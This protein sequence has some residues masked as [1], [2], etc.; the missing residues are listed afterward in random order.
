MVA[1]PL[2]CAEKAAYTGERVMAS[3]RLTCARKRRE[4]GRGAS[5]CAG[6]AQAGAGKRRRVQVGVVQAGG[7][8]GVG[9]VHS[10]VRLEGRRAPAP[11][12]QPAGQC[13]GDVPGGRRWPLPPRTSRLVAM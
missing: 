11:Q 6:Q 4:S 7:E 13:S 8:R 3:R 2:M 12:E 1:R 10:Q 9:H 5:L